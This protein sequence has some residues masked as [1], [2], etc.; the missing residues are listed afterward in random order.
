MTKFFKGK[1]QLSKQAAAPVPR[2]Y[3]EVEKEYLELRARAGEVQY[4]IYVLTKDLE[5]LNQA[6][7]SL[8]HEAAARQKLDK[9]TEA[10][11]AQKETKTEVKSV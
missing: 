6:L 1:K 3:A 9:E 5:Q 8:N 7:V 4:Q 10:V 11:Q 2:A